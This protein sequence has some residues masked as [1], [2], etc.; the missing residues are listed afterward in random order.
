MPERKASAISKGLYFIQYRVGCWSVEIG[1]IA[2]VQTENL[3]HL[4]LDAGPRL[5]KGA[6][7][8]RAMRANT[9]E[10]LFRTA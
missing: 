8:A 7:L 1:T 2:S 6:D 5:T 9:S 10:Q 4:S 3:L